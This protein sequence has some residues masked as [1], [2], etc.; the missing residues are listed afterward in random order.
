MSD[1]TAPPETIEPTSPRVLPKWRRILVTVLVV[2]GC[3]LAPISVLGVW[4]KN[5]LLNT[6]RYV[7]TVTPLANDPA[8]Q[9]ALANRITKLVVE[10]TDIESK[11]ADALPSK[12]SFVAPAVAAGLEQ[13]V[14]Q[15][16]LK[17]VQSDQFEK[18]WVDANR[19]AHPQVVALLKGEDGKRVSTKNGQVVLQLGRILTKVQGILEKAGI[20]AFSGNGST[21]TGIVL[22][23]SSELKSA[24][25]IT[26]LLQT[27]AWIL[28]VLTLLLF[29]AAIWL[30]GNRR[31][32]ILRASLGVAFG[33]ALVLVLFNSGRHFY[34]DALPATV[35]RPAAT[36][37][38]DQLLTFLRL[39]LRTMLVLAVV[40][41][42]GA[43]LSG[44]GSVATKIR[45][46]A[47]GLARGHDT[48]E[49]PSGLG[50]FVARYKTPCASP[51]SASRW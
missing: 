4:V 47:L 25:S 2:I 51:S 27:L 9:Q 42:I 36:A 24:Q 20:D 6:D 30:S 14:N 11:I 44:T 23:T 35:S 34:L 49:E 45:E 12:A 10:N 19:R 41:A 13:F 28:P 50:V 7:S 33:M 16:A 31:R 39:S 5:T 17:L 43:W 8:V 15:T 37:V 21:S 38:Y 40:V 22:F 26:D 1:A 32:T 29:A 3:V 18:L 46:G 48:G